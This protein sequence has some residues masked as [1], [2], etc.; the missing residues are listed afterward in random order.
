MLGKFFDPVALG[1]FSFAFQTVERFVGL[2]YA[3]PSS[4]LISAMGP[5]SMTDRPQMSS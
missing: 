2:V 5:Q 1:L 3:I 4:L